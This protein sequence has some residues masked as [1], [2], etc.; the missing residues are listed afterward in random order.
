MYTDNHIRLSSSQSK[1]IEKEPDGQ[2]DT[3]TSKR[4][5]SVEAMNNI[6][7]NKKSKTTQDYMKSHAETCYRKLPTLTQVPGNEKGY[8]YRYVPDVES[9]SWMSS[10]FAKSFSYKKHL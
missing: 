3:E 6:T 9:S 5:N 2:L 7:V 1:F 10:V 8:L 4:T